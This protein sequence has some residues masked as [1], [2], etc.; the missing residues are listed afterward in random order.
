MVLDQCD[1]QAVTPHEESFRMTIVHK[2]Y[3]KAILAPVHLVEQIWKDYESFK[4]SVSRA[5][6]SCLPFNQSQSL[7][8][9]QPPIVTHLWGSIKLKFSHGHPL[10]GLYMLQYGYHDL[11]FQCGRMVMSYHSEEQ[12]F[13]NCG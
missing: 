9:N 1:E 12:I 7:G 13:V 10:S 4:N 6:V 5:L 2:A 3:L 8:V 11:P